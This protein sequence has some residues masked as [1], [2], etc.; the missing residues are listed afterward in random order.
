MS[1]LEKAR[2]RYEAH[3]THDADYPRNDAD[4]YITALETALREAR[5]RCADLASC[6]ATAL[7]QLKEAREEVARYQRTFRHT[8]VAKYDGDR[9]L[10]ECGE[11]GLDIRDEVHERAAET[12]TDNVA[13]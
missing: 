6:E 9:L 7:D 3:L 11:C 8:H 10:D 12:E 13:S 5:D 4:I 2:K 1:D